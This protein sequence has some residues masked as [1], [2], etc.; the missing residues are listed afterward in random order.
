MTI[1]LGTMNKPKPSQINHKF[2]FN[3]DVVK[4]QRGTK[5]GY[6]Y[7]PV[8]GTFKCKQ[9][10]SPVDIEKKLLQ[11]YGSDICVV[12]VDEAGRGAW[13]GPMSLGF[14]VL[15]IDDYLNDD[16]LRGALCGVRDSKQISSDARRRLFH[17]VRDIASFSA[18]WYVPVNDIDNIGL[19]VATKQVINDVTDIIAKLMGKKIY[20]L[21][22]HGI[23]HNLDNNKNVVGYQD[24]TKGETVSLSIA[25]ASIIAK[26]ERDTLMMEIDDLFSVDWM[27]SNHKG[28]GTKTHKNILDKYGPIKGVHRMSFKPVKRA[29]KNGSPLSVL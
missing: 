23:S 10:T 22:D 1:W 16:E 21:L 13:A 29:L 17:V 20:Y 14:C 11:D 18:A 19:S 26:H 24:I 3:K 25:S 12:G 6:T 8:F 5:N 4:N 7:D 2:N 15:P 27:F 28:Y 9:R